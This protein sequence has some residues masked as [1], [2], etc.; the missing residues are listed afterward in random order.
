MT[1]WIWL[2]L[3]LG[4]AAVVW[5]ALVAALLLGGRRQEARALAGFVP[6]CLVL[7]SRL[8]GDERVPRR[9]KLLLAALVGY[10]ALPFDLVP[11]F[12]PVAGQLDDVLVVAF[13]LRRFLRSGGD[14]LVREHWPGPEQSLRLVLRVAGAR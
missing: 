4:L 7:V 1:W 8:L 10:L 14:E 5:L 9:R 13:V 11:D 12:I 3:A 2:A 6:D